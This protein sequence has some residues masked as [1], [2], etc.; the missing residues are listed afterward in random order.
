[1]KDEA[2]IIVEADFVKNERGGASSLLRLKR[3]DFT[4]KSF[5]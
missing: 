5:F 2:D 1:M 4:K 3:S